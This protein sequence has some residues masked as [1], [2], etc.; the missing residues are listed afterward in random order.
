[1][2]IPEHAC[3]SRR[4]CCS[5]RL[6]RD[7]TSCFAACSLPLL[8]NGIPLVVELEDPGFDASV[9]SEFRSRPAC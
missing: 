9:L 4:T 5:P 8:V 2:A 1:M 7:G 6:A 3:K